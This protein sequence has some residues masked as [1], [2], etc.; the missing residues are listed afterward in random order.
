MIVCQTEMYA[1][2][3]GSPQV[4]LDRYE[5]GAAYLKRGQFQEAI[6]A[7]E[8]LTR[9]EPANPRGWKGLG[10][11]HAS[12]GA[13][14]LA[15]SPLRKACELD[16]SDQDACYYFGLASYNLGRYETA[17]A[18]YKKALNAKGQVSRVHAGVGLTFEAL[19]RDAE[20]EMEL[21]QAVQRADGKSAADF[22]PRVELGAFLF[23]QGREHEALD[24]LE[25]AVKTRPD[26]PRGHFEMARALLQRGRL[27]D[28]VDHLK[29]AVTLDPAFTAAHLLLGRTLYRLGRDAEAEP[30]LLRVGAGR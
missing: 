5:Q 27:D 24:A 9:I 13:Y 26:S 4:V 12:Q 28:A 7:F 11:T 17:L 22:D 25:R 16:A 20:A 18:A 23:R 6:Q 3:S 8:E 29:R 30:H 1:Q 14:R 19:G 2:F 21:R 15:E 10:V